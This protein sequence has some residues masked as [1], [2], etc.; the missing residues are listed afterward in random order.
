VA[1]LLA[2][3]ALTVTMAVIAAKN[4]AG[5]RRSASRSVTMGTAEHSSPAGAAR[6]TAVSVTTHW[7]MAT[8]PGGPSTGKAS[9]AEAAPSRLDVALAVISAIP[10]SRLLTSAA[11]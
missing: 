9:A 10:V 7:R 1:A 8:T 2:L 3:T 11:P 5:T 6:H 4:L